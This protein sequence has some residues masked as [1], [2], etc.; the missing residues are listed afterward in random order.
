[1]M[2]QPDLITKKNHRLAIIICIIAAIRVFIYS[3]AF[4]FFNNTDEQVHFD[5]VIKYSEGHIPKSLETI[6]PVSADYIVRYESKEFN[7]N[8]DNYPGQ[9]FPSPI[10]KLPKENTQTYING[11]IALWTSHY[12]ENSLQAPLYYIVAGI[13]TKLGILLGIKGGWL[14]Y[15]IRDLNILLIIVLVWIAYRAASMLFSDDQFIILG[16]PLMIALL[17]QDTFYSIQSDVMS[18]ICF[19]FAFIGMVRFMKNESPH[20]LKAIAAGLATAAT[21]FV[22]IS[23]LPLFFV[24]LLTLL[25]L[26]LKS[27]RMKKLEQTRQPILL[28]V[29]FAAIPV[30]TWFAWNQYNYGDITASAEKI[31]RLG[32]SHKPVSEWFSHPIFTLQGAWTFWEGLMI[33]F[34]RGEFT[35]WATSIG[36]RVADVFYCFSSLVFP[37]FALLN[38]NKLKLEIQRKVNWFS[39]W[40]F[41]SLILF[42]VTLSLSF[43]FGA[44]FYPSKDVPFFYSGRLISSALVPFTFLFV[45]GLNLA[46]SW[47]KIEKI[48]L[49]ILFL[50]FILIS[51]SEITVNL[52]AFSSQFN[53]F[54]L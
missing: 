35:W 15:W 48:R 13:W 22:K 50:L 23:N 5:L 4:P 14:L 10:W 12:N 7:E 9:K 37:L 17:P 18:P 25:Y 19:G 45:Q 54:H 47:I 49:S 21:V 38:M 31:H 16:V 1:M 8:P 39:F 44:C 41:A 53:L 6:S 26:L 11:G 24:V 36:M 34:W 52:P 42:M 33:T 20:P 40:C 30:F 29:F 46:L 3:S 27:W 2:A 43:D 32:W 51:I 28:F